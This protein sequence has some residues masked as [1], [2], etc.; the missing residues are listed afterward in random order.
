MKNE[1]LAKLVAWLIGRLDEETL[2]GWVDA[3]LDYIED[4][5][6][7]SESTLDDAVVLPI[8]KLIRDAFGVPDND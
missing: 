5:V 6:A 4:V 7:K 8:C 2:K 3:G 1:I